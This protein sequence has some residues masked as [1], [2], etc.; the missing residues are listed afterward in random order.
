MF[1]TWISLS[2]ELVPSNSFDAFHWIH[3]LDIDESQ[4]VGQSQIGTLLVYCLA[5]ASG[6]ASVVANE[7][8][9]VFTAKVNMRVGNVARRFHVILEP[10]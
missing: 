1:S 8:C 5:P 3:N 9:R 2:D 10:F 6:K 4:I 7:H